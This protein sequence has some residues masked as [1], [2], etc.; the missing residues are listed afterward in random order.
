MKCHLAITLL[1]FCFL[2]VAQGATQAAEPTSGA[3]PN[4]VLVLAD[5]LGINDLACYGRKDHRTP[6]LDGLTTQGMRFTCAYAQPVCSPSRAALL[7]GKCPARL[8]LTNY[9][10]GRP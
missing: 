3:R 6:N 7:T 9:L 1:A 8:N 5:D 10:P 4:I 2:S